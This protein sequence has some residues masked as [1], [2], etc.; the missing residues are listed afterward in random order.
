MYPSGGASCRA[1]GGTSE[2]ALEDLAGVLASTEGH[3]K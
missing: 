3:S 2:E 1:H